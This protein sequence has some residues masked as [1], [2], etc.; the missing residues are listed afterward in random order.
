MP[1]I[2]VES[3]PVP[4]AST[5]P[6]PALVIEAEKPV[7][8]APEPEPSDETSD[9]KY[10][11]LEWR[12]NKLSLESRQ[13]QLQRKEEEIERKT[14]ELVDLR[15]KVEEAKN[16]LQARQ[17]EVRAKCKFTFNN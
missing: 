16:T 6:A 13:K 5:S 11:W 3:A 15:M 8:M 9:K 10:L 2:P 1:L 7:E 4:N 12:Q 17:V 14:Q